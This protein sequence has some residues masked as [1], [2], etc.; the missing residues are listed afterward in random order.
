MNKRF[1][2]IDI[3]GYLERAFY[4]LQSPAPT[5]VLYAA[6]DLRLSFEKIILKHGFASDNFSTTFMKLNFKPEQLYK[7]LSIEYAH[8]MNLNFGYRF[9][10]NNSKNEK[11]KLFGY[12]LP[13]NKELFAQYGKL[14][15]FLHANWAI[16]LGFP[17]R[18]W[19]V[20]KSKD[21]RDFA[22][23]LIPH[24]NSKNSLDWINIPNISI[25]EMDI[26]IVNTK[27]LDYWNQ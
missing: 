8:K 16:P 18:R 12:F 13:I 7:S 14:D 17:D 3:P 22:N 21:L 11:E 9:F 25:A 2:P 26:S 20:E 23:K 10:L 4:W 19:Q 1:R 6:L 5:G 24:A 15:N 27:L